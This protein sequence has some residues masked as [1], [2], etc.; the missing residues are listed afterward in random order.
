MLKKILC[1]GV[2]ICLILSGCSK[3]TADLP[4]PGDL[5]S[6]VASAAGL[7]EM[8]ELTP[9]ELQN[10]IGINPEDYVDYAAY[11]ASWG[12][13]PDEIIIVRAVDE[14]K[15]K[16]I[17]ELLK[18]RVEYKRKSSEVYLTENLPIISEAVVQRDG[19][20]VAMLITENIEAAKSEYN[21]L[22]NQKND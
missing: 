4:E 14:S 7:S 15:A 16:D 2:L 1:I 8:I 17:E 11:Q 6:A 19:V 13:S 18:S 12:M 10:I 21:K 5:Y 20:T 3:K 9:E 22:K